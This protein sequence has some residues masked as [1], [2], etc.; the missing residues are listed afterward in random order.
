M[1]AWIW[2]AGE[3]SCRAEQGVAC[4]RRARGA[5]VVVAAKRRSKSAGASSGHGSTR[6]R[7]A[8]QARDAAGRTATARHSEFVCLCGR[9]SRLLVKR[10]CLVQVGGRGGSGWVSQA[11]REHGDGHV[12]SRP[13]QRA[14]CDTCTVACAL[15]L[16]DSE[17]NSTKT[18]GRRLE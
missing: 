8:S 17:V 14:V 4:S 18:D 11:T 7:C 6:V 2:S 5:R 15:S 16:C 1:P 12:P 3:E 9:K 10:M 13:L